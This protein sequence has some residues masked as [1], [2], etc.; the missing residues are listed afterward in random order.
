MGRGQVA[1]ADQPLPG[2]R[3]QVHI[4]TYRRKYPH[5]RREEIQGLENLFR[6]W[7]ED[8]NGEIS[9]EEMA[10]MLERVVRDLFDNMDKD[11]S[12]A[13]NT[14]EVKNLCVMLGQNLNDKEFKEAMSHMDKDHGGQ[15]EFEEFE[16]WWKGSE[17][18][19][20]EANT[21][22]LVDL[23]SEVDEDGSGEIDIDEFVKMIALKMEN[24]SGARACSLSFTRFCSFS[25]AHTCKS[26]PARAFGP[27]IAPCDSAVVPKQET[28]RSVMLS[29]AMTF[30]FLQRFLLC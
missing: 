21:E 9:L 19:S 24:K 22:E 23:F 17:E 27:S 7:D 18:G 6:T 29:V 11:G 25:L 2:G 3:R 8:G 14:K 26:V 5:M 4:E 10:V 12:G 20:S 13:L 15:V 30:C 16:A 1:P 28:I